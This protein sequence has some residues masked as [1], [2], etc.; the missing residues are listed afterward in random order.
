MLGKSEWNCQSHSSERVVGE[1]LIKLLRF[2]P[3]IIFRTES[4]P[5]I[6]DQL[7]EV[8]IKSP[9]EQVI[10]GDRGLF[11]Q[12]NIEKRK[13]M[14]VREWVELCNK[15]DYR[16]PG[17]RE[18]NLAQR[19]V[20][21]ESRPKIQRRGKRKRE[22][23]NVG[24]AI[25]NMQVK[26]E[27]TDN[28]SVSL[29]EENSPRPQSVSDEKQEEL[30]PTS[31]VEVKDEPKVRPKRVYPSREAR[32]ANLAD[33]AARDRTFVDLFQP[34]SAW[35]PPN[36]LAEDYNPE[37]CQQLERR[38]WRGLGLGGKPAW[39]GADTQGMCQLYSSM[40]NDQMT[41]G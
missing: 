1:H 35:L 13:W 7:A 21:V 26:D 12:Q 2:I 29:S 10:F 4:L 8:K 14:S 22:S 32:E 37:F 25:D 15:E 27:P 17:V 31:E 33:R 16:A 5:S 39:Y 3:S 18:V 28:V 19:T 9:I 20:P 34:L 6:K 40:N 41:H 38:F 11:R 36:T 30:P 23:D 24:P